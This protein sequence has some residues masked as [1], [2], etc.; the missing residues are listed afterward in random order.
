MSAKGNHSLAETA[1]AYGSAQRTSSVKVSITLPADLVEEVRIA[2]SQT[3]TG[4]SGVIAA[5]LRH[6]LAVAQQA[7]IDEALALDA[8]DNAEYGRVGEALAAETWAELKW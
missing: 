7:R 6:S 3:G 4:V 2:A 8:A 1:A 5:A